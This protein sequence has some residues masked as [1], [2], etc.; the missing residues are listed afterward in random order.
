MGAIQAFWKGWRTRRAG[1][2]SFQDLR[3]R[4][5]RS[6]AASDAAPHKQLAAR[7]EAALQCLRQSKQHVQVQ[8]RGCVNSWLEQSGTALMLLLK[9]C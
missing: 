3:G 7:T 2:N 6:A 5:L 8:T 9:V 4:M 1:G